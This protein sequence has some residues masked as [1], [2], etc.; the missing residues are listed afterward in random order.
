MAERQPAAPEFAALAERHGVQSRA[1]GLQSAVHAFLL[2]HD[3]TRAL[4]TANFSP[5]LA[6]PLLADSY[7][8]ELYGQ[9][10]AE[11][12]QIAGNL[13][14]PALR[15]LAVLNPRTYFSIASAAGYAPPISEIGAL[16]ESIVRERETD[17]DE[18]DER[19]E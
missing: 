7:I 4:K 14:G 13:D 11:L 2:G 12:R 5:T 9:R 8:Q 19:N 3:L 15:G 6:A 17:H 18:R 1:K 16:I 10:L